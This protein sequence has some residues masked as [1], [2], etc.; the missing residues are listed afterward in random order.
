MTNPGAVVYRGEVIGIWTTKKKA[1][2]MDIKMTLWTDAAEKT[3]LQ[4]LAEEYAAFRQQA[5]MNLEIAQL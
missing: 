3:P 4:N 5:L 1:K 2:G